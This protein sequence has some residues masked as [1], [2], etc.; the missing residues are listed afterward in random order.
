MTEERANYRVEGRPEGIRPETLLCYGDANYAE[1]TTDDI[2]AALTIKG[3]SGSE[4]GELLGVNGRTIRKWTGGEQAMP[5]SAWR[6]LLLYSGL[7]EHEVLPR[8]ALREK[9][10]EQ[11]RNLHDTLR[12]KIKGNVGVMLDA[13]ARAEVVDMNDGCLR[14][15]RRRDQNQTGKR[16]PHRSPPVRELSL[17]Q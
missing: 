8:A 3:L 14:R 11:L 2:R 17:T 4:A 5:Y 1:P 7:V 16:A 10:T 13:H 9:T 6:L 15:S 12:S